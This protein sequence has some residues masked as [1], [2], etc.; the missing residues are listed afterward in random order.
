M[1]YEVIHS[2]DL[3]MYLVRQ[4]FD[5]AKICDSEKNS[6]YKVFMFYKSKELSNAIQ[7]YKPNKNISTT[8][9]LG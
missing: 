2:K 5:V 3:M 9:H 1:E 8:N 7:H 6:K 4:G